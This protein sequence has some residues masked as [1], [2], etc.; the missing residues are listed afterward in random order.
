MPKIAPCLWFDD[1][2][3]ETATFYTS[4]FPNFRITEV[5]RYPEAGPGVAAGTVSTVSF[6]LDG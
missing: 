2:G 4:V 6:S 3:E 1:Q 5:Q